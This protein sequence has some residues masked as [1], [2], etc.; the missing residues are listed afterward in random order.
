VKRPLGT[1]RRRWENTIKVDLRE[2]K[3]GGLDWIDLDQNRYKWR[4]LLNTVMNFQ[5]P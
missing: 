1:H 5:V 2:V 4:E 3:W